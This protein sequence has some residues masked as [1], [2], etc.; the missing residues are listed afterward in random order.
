MTFAQRRNRPTHFSERIPVVK[1]R[2]TVQEHKLLFRWE[3]ISFSSLPGYPAVLYLY[4]RILILIDVIL[5]IPVFRK[6]TPCS[7]HT[8]NNVRGKSAS[9]VD[10]LSNIES[11][12]LKLGYS[13]IRLN[14]DIF[15]KTVMLTIRQSKVS[16]SNLRQ[17]SHACRWHPTWRV[18]HWETWVAG[19]AVNANLQ[20]ANSI[21]PSRV[22]ARARGSNPLPAESSRRMS[23]VNVSATGSQRV[24]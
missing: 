11:A 6:V 7:S 15:Q 17:F 12:P 2:M 18:R 10:G 24:N 16:Q 20:N 8:C 13:I 9:M 5:Q 14:G 3:T 19:A 21:P 1:R 23:C 4:L 22:I